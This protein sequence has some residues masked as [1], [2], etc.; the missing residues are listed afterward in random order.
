[1]PKTA[2]ASY[3]NIGT[4]KRNQKRIWLEGL[5]MESCGF[6]KGESYTTI[7]DVQKRSLSLVLDENGPRKVSGRKKNGK[8]LPIIEIANAQVTRHIEKV[9]GN[10]NRVRVTFTYNRIDISVHHEDR[11]QVDRETQIKESIAQGLLTEA[12]VCAG[13]T[14]SCMALHQGFEMAGI[15]S[16]CEFLV[17]MEGKYI[18]SAMNNNPYITD[19]TTI[20]EATL[21]ELEP[22]LIKDVLDARDLKGIDVLNFS[23]PC[24]GASQAG[25]AKNGNKLAEEHSSAGTAVVGLLQIIHATNPCV[26]ISENVPQFAESATHAILRSYFEKTGYVIQEAVLGKEMGAFEDRKRH[27]MIG[28]SKGIAE[29]FDMQHIKPSGTPPVT[30]AEIMDDIPEDSPVWKTYDYLKEKEVRDKAE[31][32]SFARQIVTPDAE[33][34]GTIGRGYFK[35]RSTEPFIQH[36]TD[37]ERSRLLTVDEHARAKG[38]PEDLVAGQSQT[39]AHEILGQSVL[40]PVFKSIGALIGAHLNE[41]DLSIPENQQKIDDLTNI[42]RDSVDFRG[43]APVPVSMIE[44]WLFFGALMDKA[45]EVYNEVLEDQEQEMDDSPGMRM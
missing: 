39:T 2:Q 42:I 34:I 43:G 30:L 35:A 20:F 4:D 5:K 21:E 22:E 6:A 29:T 32:K 8:V 40:F 33:S 41:I 44:S 11:K 14:V 37:P 27:I 19:D 38:I 36:P 25:R 1:M 28:I 18:Q 17:E 24:T 3:I 10:V 13:G 26:V 31:G 45:R 9:M 15:K 23:L 7:F 12:T 16:T